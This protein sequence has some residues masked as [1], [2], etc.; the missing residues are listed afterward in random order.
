MYLLV[1]YFCLSQFIFLKGEVIK[2]TFF[3]MEATLQP[4]H[5]SMHVAFITLCKLQCSRLTT[6]ISVAETNVK[7]TGI[8]T[9][10]NCWRSLKVAGKKN[11]RVRCIHTYIELTFVRTMGSSV[12]FVSDMLSITLLALKSSVTMTFHTKNLSVHRVSSSSFSSAILVTK[13]SCVDSGGKIPS[14]GFT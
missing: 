13:S 4:L 9:W 5:Q 11:E 8:S 7:C 2:I 10:G 1:F 14:D 12:H 6:R 3:E